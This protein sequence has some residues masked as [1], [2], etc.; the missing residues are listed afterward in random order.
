MSALDDGRLPSISTLP[1]AP[2]RPRAL[3]SPLST[4]KPGTRCIMSSAVLGRK[5]AKK[6]GW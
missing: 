3:L 4:P 1:A 5:L 2:D 6:S